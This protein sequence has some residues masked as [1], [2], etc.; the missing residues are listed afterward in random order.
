MNPPAPVT[1]ARF[2]MSLL[3]PGERP[4]RFGNMRYGFHQVAREPLGAPAFECG[5]DHEG[6][7]GIDVAACIILARSLEKALE[8]RKRLELAHVDERRW[9]HVLRDVRRAAVDGNAARKEASRMPSVTYPGK[10]VFSYT[11]AKRYVANNAS[12]SA[13]GPR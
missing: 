11:S 1:R 2:T 4:S 5:R 13:A 12:R 7:R 6:I 8:L 3:Y 10:R 9:R